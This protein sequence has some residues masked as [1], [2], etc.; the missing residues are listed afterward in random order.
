MVVLAP[1]NSA[2]FPPGGLLFGLSYSFP[3]TFHF[4]SHIASVCHIYQ[5]CSY[6]VY[7]IP[8]ILHGLP[9]LHYV[10]RGPDP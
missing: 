9:L 8:D 3:S 2:F 1:P 4:W 7:V 5:F 10:G 6:P